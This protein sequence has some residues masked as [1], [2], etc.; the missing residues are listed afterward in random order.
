MQIMQGRLPRASGRRGFQI[1]A[2]SVR[3]VAAGMIGALALSGCASLYNPHVRPP[4]DKRTAALIDPDAKF[5]GT[6]P[7]AIE[8]ANLQRDLYYNAVGDQ[9]RLRSTLALTLAPLTAVAL[10]LGITSSSGFSRDVI[11]G[12]GI[13]GATFFGLGTFF[14][15]KTRQKVYLE[16]SRVIGCAI[17]AMGPV[18][19]TEDDYKTLKNKLEGI[20][21][22]TA[23]V[24]QRIGRLEG[25]I[26]DPAAL[27]AKWNAEL[28][29]FISGAEAQIEALKSREI[30]LDK[31]VEDLIDEINE[32]QADLED[33]LARQQP[34]SQQ[35]TAPL[36]LVEPV[37][38]TKNAL[39]PPATATPS[40]MTLSPKQ[41]TALAV[42]IEQWKARIGNLGIEKDRAE[43]ALREITETLMDVERAF[44]SQVT[45]LARSAGESNDE[46]I[47]QRIKEAKAEIAAAKKLKAAAKTASGDGSVLRDRVDKAGL[48]LTTIVE[49]I[50]D[51]VSLE[52][53]KTEPSLESITNITDNLGS[54]ASKFAG[55]EL[56]LPTRDAPPQTGDPAAEQLL[57][58]DVEVQAMLGTP[59]ETPVQR[60][61]AAIRNLQTAELELATA[62][63]AVTELV[64]RAAAASQTA[65][66]IT[67]CQV[68]A[69]ASDFKVE[70][71]VSEIELTLPD[72]T[73]QFV[74]S[75]GGIP[76]AA[77]VGSDAAGLNAKPVL[78]GGS[79]VVKIS[80]EQD[81]PPK[82]DKYLL[83]ISDSS[84]S[85][86]KTIDVK[87][88]PAPSEPPQPGADGEG[89]LRPSDISHLLPAAQPIPVVGGESLPILRSPAPCTE[90]S[91]I[92]IRLDDF[93][94]REL[95]EK[96]G[97]TAD[98]I[99]GP[100]TISA[101][102]GYQMGKG[103]CVTG[104]LTVQDVEELFGLS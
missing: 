99:I 76:R 83:R 15:S 73:Y 3:V 89:L 11:A 68:Q 47:K 61:E 6:L 32:A 67:S 48:T 12:L 9:S 93:R 102:K 4:D 37:P 64:A 24:D 77:F 17:I 53:V 2:A 8:Y 34:S 100:K 36:A 94:I 16:G 58:G 65:G 80:M 52:L 35:Q 79:Y 84:D 45:Q 25:M 40:P 38:S 46:V 31:K 92:Q 95:Q 20:R 104:R 82:A 1:R 86:S 103:R 10:Y 13:G 5:Q 22:A 69:V 56:I 27:T 97:L 90:S 66:D 54:L 87:V 44:N 75:G 39:Q 74:I 51:Q 30:D 14:E 63:N 33:L 55:T 78:E 23:K 96:L 19:M 50:R 26:A 18:L 57:D 43:T 42:S 29:G 88:L 28:I 72:G 91:E 71:D 70:P 81:N 59:P 41:A 85:A 60:I 98:G 7:K 49:N 21:A 62:A 101:I